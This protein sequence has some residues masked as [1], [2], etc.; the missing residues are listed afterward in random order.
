MDFIEGLPPSK[1]KDAMLVVLDRL[2][3]YAHFIPLK[4][5]FIAYSAATFSQKIVHGFPSS[6]VSD[7]VRIF[8]SVFWRELFRLQVTNS[9]RST[10]TTHKRMGNPKW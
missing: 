6:I 9:Q 7:R 8:M 3:K 4:H 1:G 10:L 2:T 5:P